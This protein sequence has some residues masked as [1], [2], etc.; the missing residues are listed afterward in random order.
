MTRLNDKNFLARLAAL[1][2]AVVSLT[3]ERVHEVDIAALHSEVQTLMTHC[4]KRKD[5]RGRRYRRELYQALHV[6]KAHIDAARVLLDIQRDFP[7]IVGT[8]GN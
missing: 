2:A 8:S 7:G 4:V 3:P 6:M 1:Q 5:W